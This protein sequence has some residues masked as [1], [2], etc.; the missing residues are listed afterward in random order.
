MQIAR[1]EQRTINQRKVSNANTQ[2][3]AMEAIKME[4]QVLEQLTGHPN[5]TGL[6]STFQDQDYLCI[7]KNLSQSGVFLGVSKSKI[8]KFVVEF[9][10]K[11]TPENT[12]TCILLS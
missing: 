5:I 3:S 11:I 4:K 7:H 12:L 9:E 1:L 2:R 6:G 10:I 8:K